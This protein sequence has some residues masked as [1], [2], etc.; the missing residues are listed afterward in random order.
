[1]KPRIPQCCM[2]PE[3]RKF[4]VEVIRLEDDANYDCCHI[5]LFNTGVYNQEN[6]FKP[7]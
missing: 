3:E 5:D 2:I 7:N 1:M 6:L 4:H